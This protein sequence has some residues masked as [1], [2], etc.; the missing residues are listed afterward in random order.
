MPAP[1]NT[2]PIS[3]RIRFLLRHYSYAAPAPLSVQKYPAMAQKEG[4]AG[5]HAS[6][7]TDGIPPFM[8]VNIFKPIHIVIY[9]KQRG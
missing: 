5:A 1:T 7:T 9:D 3:H 4:G 6:T 8:H 2:T